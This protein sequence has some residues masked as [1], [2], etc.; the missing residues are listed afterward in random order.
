MSPVPLSLDT[1]PAVEQMQ[2]DAWRRMTPEQKAATVRGLT[3][4]TFRLAMAGIRHRHP[5]ASPHEQRLHLAL[6]ILGPTLALKVFP[7]IA[8]LNDR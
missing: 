1:S 4:A 3:R 2:V 5:G 7:E 8:R 6:V